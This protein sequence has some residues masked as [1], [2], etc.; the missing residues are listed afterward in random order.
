MWTD[1]KLCANVLRLRE[2]DHFALRL[3]TSLGARL[4]V[5]GLP[6]IHPGETFEWTKEGALWFPG[7]Y[8]ASVVATPDGQELWSGRIKVQPQ[9]ESFTFAEQ[10]MEEVEGWIKGISRDPSLGIVSHATNATDP[11]S[12][13]LSWARIC[14]IAIERILT[15]PEGEF[16]PI[17]GRPCFGCNTPDNRAV[18]KALITI[19]L[20]LASRL[21]IQRS[22]FPNQESALIRELDDLYRW[23]RRLEAHPLWDNVDPPSAHD[24]MTQRG[25]RR[26]AY[27]LLQEAFSRWHTAP[28]AVP[29][30]CEITRVRPTPELF[31]LWVLKHL[32][33]N[34]AQL[35]WRLKESP[36]WY[37]IGRRMGLVDP[38]GLRESRFVLTRDQR[39]LTLHYDKA[40]P[41]NGAMASDGIWMSGP[42]N[43]PDFI[44]QYDDG[45]VPPLIMIIEAKYRRRH[46]KWT[47]IAEPSSVMTQLNQYWSSL[48]YHG[49]HL[50]PP[51]LC[52]LP[53][54]E[55][56]IWRPAG[57]ADIEFLAMN[58]TSSEL[59]WSEHLRARLEQPLTTRS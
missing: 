30:G 41:T 23:A 9:H 17:I 52:V 36:A 47:D 1:W 28:R 42:H 8:R 13:D 38:M 34:L 22:A 7:E 18:R 43:R 14:L 50:D 21:S 20:S 37:T 27:R 15:H 31:E 58:P 59:P 35:G 5:E 54:L 45:R 19:R 57:Y 46:P 12:A 4:I 10:I 56:L 33:E 16:T 53:E 3:D 44:L 2:Y 40:L 25:Q 55:E 51:V 24:R 32:L 11:Q 49:Q 48:M 29:E 39:T 26:R 6:V